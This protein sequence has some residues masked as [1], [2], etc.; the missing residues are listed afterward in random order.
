MPYSLKHIKVVFPVKHSLVSQYRPPSWR[1]S[2]KCARLHRNN[3]RLQRG[4]CRCLSDDGSF[5]ASDTEHAIALPRLLVFFTS[6]R[7][8]NP[9]VDVRQREGDQS[10]YATKPQNQSRPSSVCRHTYASC[11]ASSRSYGRPHATSTYACVRQLRTFRLSS[12]PQCAACLAS[13]PDTASPHPQISF[14]FLDRIVRP[15]EWHGQCRGCKLSILHPS[16]SSEAQRGT[17]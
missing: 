14:D 13:Q 17:R 16:S 9:G 4:E 7:S 8:L 5:F 2:A 11:R 3:F 6:L 1:A 12:S 15:T 10:H